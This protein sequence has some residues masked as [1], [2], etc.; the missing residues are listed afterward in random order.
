MSQ[1]RAQSPLTLTFGYCL[2]CDNKAAREECQLIKTTAEARGLAVHED[3]GEG[4]LLFS[5]QA[6]SAHMMELVNQLSELGLMMQTSLEF[7]NKRTM[8]QFSNIAHM[9]EAVFHHQGQ[10]YVAIPTDQPEGFKR[11]ISRG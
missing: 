1:Q 2:C 8:M 11:R 6:C 5:I 9:G 10:T 3:S 7:P 4:V